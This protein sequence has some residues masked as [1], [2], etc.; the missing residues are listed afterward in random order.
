MNTFTKSLASTIR[1]S[2]MI[3][4]PELL[5]KY[6]QRLSFYS[7]TVSTFEQLTLAHFISEGYYEKHINRM[8]TAYRKK[9]DYLLSCI[10][11]SGLGNISEINEEQSGLHFILKLKL[12]IPEEKFL[13]NLEENDIHIVST[14]PQSYM[15]NYSSIPLNK[16]SEA[17]NRINA[18]TNI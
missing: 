7:C 12:K 17:I 4:P 5:N 8:R 10:K 16:I 18:A 13:K 6:Y 2:Y 11:D 9:R 1:I 14:A 3:L 15:I